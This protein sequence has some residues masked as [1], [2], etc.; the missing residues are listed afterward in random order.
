MPR[1]KI[2]ADVAVL[3]LIV[4]VIIEKGATTFSLQDLSKK[5]GLSPATLLQRFG[6]KKNILHRAIELANED[7]KQKLNNSASDSKSII[8]QII[9]IYLDLSLS[10]SKPAD[11]A[12]GLD[13][14]KLDILEK[15]LND[16]TRNYYK[17]RRN[18]IYTL[19]KLAQKQQEILI[20]HGA[21]EIAWNLECLWQGSI[22]LWA[23]TG[24][25]E[26]KKWLK[27]RFTSYLNLLK[28]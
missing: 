11:I 5:T 1:T 23:L 25:G 27:S 18:K 14:L 12:N 6:S 21:K 2:M 10:F 7:L 22:M 19:I 15:K 16:L 17:I 13:I 8:Q 4:E 20:N 28:S 26:L 24:S 9:N 3:K